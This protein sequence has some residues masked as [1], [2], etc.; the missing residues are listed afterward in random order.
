VLKAEPVRILIPNDAIQT[1][2]NQSVVFVP[3]GEVYKPQPV[4]VGRAN[5]TVSQILAGLE[6]GNRYVAKGAFVLKAELG[7]GAMSCS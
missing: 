4:T 6:P 1:V 7:L 5:A 2:E 3:A